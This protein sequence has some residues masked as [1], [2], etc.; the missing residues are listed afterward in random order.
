M[1]TRAAPIGRREHDESG[2]HAAGLAGDDF[3]QRGDPGG[4]ADSEPVARGQARATR[5]REEYH[6]LRLHR[7]PPSG[8]VAGTSAA[9]RPEDIHSE[10]SHIR[11]NE[12]SCARRAGALSNRPFVWPRCSGGRGLFVLRTP[13]CMDADR[14]SQRLI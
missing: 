11:G 5:H 7:K 13:G 3:L 12:V 10:N 14:E 9:D 2:R 6:R 8:A 1:A 4:A